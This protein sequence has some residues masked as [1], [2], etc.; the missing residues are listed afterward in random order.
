LAVEV[1]RVEPVQ[2][3]RAES[4][5][6]P[7]DAALVDA[8][9]SAFAVQWTEFALDAA[10]SREDL[11]LHLPSDWDESA[12]SGRVLDVGCGMGRYTALVAD[13]GAEV[14][15]LDVSRAVEKAA[16]LWPQCS[17]VQG[18]IVAPPFRPE[19]FDLVYSFGVLHHLPDPLRGLRRCYELVKPGGRLLVW[20]YSSRGGILRI[21]RR[22][23]RCGV[24]RVP[25][26]LRPL[27]YAAAAVLFLTCIL[28]RKLTGSQRGRMTYYDTKG[29]RQLFVDCYDALAAP[30]EVYL[31]EHD[32]QQWL[33]VLEA[34]RSGFERRRDGSGWILWAVK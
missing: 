23:A 20:V 12:F 29:F 1:A 21:G 19:S 30:L 25:P 34:P 27:A 15:G 5:W 2:A 24:R 7:V 3:P 32:C 18:D 31:S 33:A 11:L 4:G 17:F 8:T 28:P 16:E 26:L 22:V 10:V 14:V 6:S 13:H 9:A